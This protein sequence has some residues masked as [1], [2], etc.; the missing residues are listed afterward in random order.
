MSN[1]RKILRNAFVIAI[2]IAIGLFINQVLA[3]TPDTAGPIMRPN[4]NWNS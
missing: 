2:L 3:P 4:V 1:F